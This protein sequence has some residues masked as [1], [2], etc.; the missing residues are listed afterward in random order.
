MERSAGELSRAWFYQ[1]VL[2]G[3]RLD[4]SLRAARLRARLF[5]HPPEARLTLAPEV[6][7]FQDWALSV[8]LG[9]ESAAA[10]PNSAAEARM[11]TELA[12]EV[13]RRVPC[14]AE[15][16]SRVEGRASAHLA[17]ALRVGGQ[18]RRADEEFA[19]ALGLWG[20]GAASDPAGLLDPVR[21]LDLEASLRKDQRRLARRLP[22]S[23]APSPPGPP[24]RSRGASSSRR[25]ARWGS[26]SS[27][28]S[29]RPGRRS[30][31]ARHPPPLPSGRRPRGDDRRPRPPAH[32]GPPRRGGEG[33]AEKLHL[34]GHAA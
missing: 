30:R 12:V 11:P 20:A 2:E 15:W 23:T 27:P 32:G 24:P 31:G 17:N 4:A 6:P 7:D 9:D 18:I 14:T 16:R 25:A 21:M 33:S 3:E 13:A 26:S 10:A 22:S 29:S 19:R 8:L 34:K 1:L 5:E 28:P